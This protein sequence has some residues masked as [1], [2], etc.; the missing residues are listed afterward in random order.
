MEQ[1][2]E[3]AIRMTEG[4]GFRIDSKGVSTELGFDPHCGMEPWCVAVVDAD[5]RCLHSETVPTL[6]IG[7]DRLALLGSATQK[8]LRGLYRVD[9]PGGGSFQRPGN[10]P[11]EE[12]LRKFDFDLVGNAQTYLIA[13][14]D[15]AITSVEAHEWFSQK[16]GVLAPLMGSVDLVE[17]DANGGHWCVDVLLPVNG[18]Y[19]PEGLMEFA[20]NAV[21]HCGVEMIPEVTICDEAAPDLRSGEVVQFAAGRAG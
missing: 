5:G 14:L 10:V 17:T 2:C 12:I 20:R 19:S 3:T 11:A 18:F 6:D 15:A 21:G 1:Q 9:L 4:G 16:L 7:L 13:P 8:G